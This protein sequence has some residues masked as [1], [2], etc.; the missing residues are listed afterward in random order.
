MTFGHGGNIYEVARQ[1]K[2]RP[3]D[4]IDMS[5]NINPLGPPPG[6]LD[7]LNDNLSKI[8]R[9]PEIDNQDTIKSVAEFL[10]LEPER[11]LVGN[12]TTEF[13]YLIPRA[14]EIKKSLIVGP[15]YSDYQDALNRNQVPASIFL[16]GE[17]EGFQPDLNR[18]S[19]CLN[20]FDTVYLCN[21]NNPTGVLL[22]H[23]RLYHLCQSHPEVRFIVDESYLPFVLNA[24]KETMLK[25]GLSNVLVLLS[26]SKIF[27][28]PGL[29]I[30]FVIANQNH[31]K[32][33]RQHLLPWSVN[34]LAQEAVRFLAGRKKQIEAFLQKTRTFCEKQ[35]L[36]FH[37]MFKSSPNIK[38]YP[39]R[40]PFIL[41]KLA[42]DLSARNV[43]CQL[44]EELLLIRNC[45]NFQ[46]LSDHFIRISLKTPET[47]RLMGAKLKVL[48]KDATMKCATERIAC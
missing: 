21:P 12:G 19:K 48:A 46:G 5:S 42:L 44:A 14:L 38:L 34:S 28:I 17:S 18:I 33:I 23:E 24:E 1:Y 27:G 3:S 37:D 45:E 41:A 2:C 4:I 6:L 32:K 26:I 25:S 8:T 35:R 20:Q 43:R 10:A 16:A 13:I 11:L 40:T 31:I 15:T 30:G 36:Q 47:N 39:G 7:F 9:L 29:R 22:S